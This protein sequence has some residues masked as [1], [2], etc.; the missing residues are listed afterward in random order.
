M[1]TFGA[2]NVN[3]ICMV[4]GE[5]RYSSDID[6]FKLEPSIKVVPSSVS[7]GDTVN[8]FAQDYPAGGGGF[9]ELK[10]AGQVV[11]SS[12]V[13][14]NA[15]AVRS[16]SLTDGAATAT[17][18]VPGSVGEQALAGHRARGRHVGHHHRGRQDHG[19]RL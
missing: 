15:V 6:D 4:D 3:Q 10:L 2:G 16:T 8:V 17:F 13:T 9:V 18:D 12:S 5:N 14:V 1:P 11:Y 7:S 19:G